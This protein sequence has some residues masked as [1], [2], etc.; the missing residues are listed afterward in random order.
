LARF[1]C[2][3]VQSDEQFAGERDA[4]DHFGFALVEETLAKLG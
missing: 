1:S 2:H 3:C 4:Y